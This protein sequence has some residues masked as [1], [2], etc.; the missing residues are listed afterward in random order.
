MTEYPSY[1][2]WYSQTKLKPL[3][4]ELSDPFEQQIWLYMCLCYKRYNEGLRQSK[5]VSK[6][7]MI[8]HLINCKLMSYAEDKRTG[9]K[10]L[11]DDRRIREIC[12][13]LLYKGYPIMASSKRSG[14]YI[15]DTLEEIQ[16]PREENEK[17]AKMLLAANR[18]Y[19]KV[20]QLIQYDR[21]IN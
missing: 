13:G 21:R 9:E 6:E 4:Y 12:R 17:R 10:K 11:P 7:E 15:A 18:G 16:A 14:W 2:K 20:A 19:N 1:W 5:Y 3:Y 8:K